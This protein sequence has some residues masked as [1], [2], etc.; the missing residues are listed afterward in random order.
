MSVGD[1][2]GLA[3]RAERVKSAGETIWGETRRRW[4]TARKR[5]S[6]SPPS[7]RIELFKLD[8]AGYRP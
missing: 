6:S 3:R 4:T 2:T 1:V 5:A 7:A 8:S